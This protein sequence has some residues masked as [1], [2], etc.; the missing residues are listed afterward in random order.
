MAESYDAGPIVIQTYSAGAQ[1]IQ[2]FEAGSFVVP[3]VTILTPTDLG[4]VQYWR[5]WDGDSITGLVDGNDVSTASNLIGGGVSLIPTAVGKEPV[6][7]TEILGGRDAISLDATQFLKT[8]ANISL[9]AYSVFMIAQLSPP[10]ANSLAYEFT[11]IASTTSGFY[12]N[13]YTS[14]MMLAKNTGGQ[15]G[16][17]TGTAWWGASSPQMTIQRMDG[18]HAGH[19]FWLNDS[20]RTLS[21]LGGFA[22]DPGTATI[23]DNFYIGG[24]NGASLPITGYISEIAIFPTAILDAV[25]PQLEAYYLANY[26]T[27]Y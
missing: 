2:S 9:G 27:G 6:W 5:F 18:T 12:L 13:A 8:S 1:T 4:A 17:S 20:E 24:R 25:R 7:R 14:G 22:T 16:Y 21:P 3:Q 10:A 26:D 11:T 19:D 15:S 23:T